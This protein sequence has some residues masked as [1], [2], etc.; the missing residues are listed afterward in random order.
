M[1]AGTEK[2]IQLWDIA[3]AR[4]REK[5]LEFAKDILGLAFSPDGRRLAA[6]SGEG[7]V[8][9]WD[10]A[11]G[12]L[13]DPPFKAERMEAAFFDMQISADGKLV[14]TRCTFGVFLWRTDK[15]QRLPFSEHKFTGAMS[16][17]GKA[18]VMSVKDDETVSSVSVEDPLTGQTVAPLP[19]ARFALELP[20]EFSPDGKLLAIPLEDQTVELWDL[21][22]GKPHG[23]R[24]VN[25]QQIQRLVFAPDGKLLVTVS[26]SGTL[27]LWDVA[28]GQ[29][30]GP[31]WDSAGGLKA[32]QLGLPLQIAFSPDGRWL[33]TVGATHL[34]LWPLPKAALSLREMELRT[35]LATGVRLNDQGA[36]QSIPGPEW[37]VLRRELQGLEAG[38]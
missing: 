36:W 31:A 16:P 21:A 14:A 37:H 8:Q 2:G 35:W 23:P 18:L 27:R 29:Q 6:M 38:Q 20:A 11:T 28:S 30:L 13:H 1:A 22:T 5:P 3:A 26:P 17:Q 4:P 25:R 12:K 19:Y 9:M 32:E 34:R 10:P 33:G 15:G 24:L 7:V